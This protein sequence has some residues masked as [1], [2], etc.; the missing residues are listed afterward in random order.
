MPIAE[1]KAETWVVRS[2][3]FNIRNPQWKT[4]QA[5]GHNIRHAGK[6]QNATF[7]TKQGSTKR[8]T[9]VGA[10]SKPL[11]DLRSLPFFRIEDILMAPKLFFFESFTSTDGIEA[12]ASPAHSPKTRRRPPGWSG[13]ARVS[14]SGCRPCPVQRLRLQLLQLPRKLL[15]GPSRSCWGVRQALLPSFHGA[16]QV[17]PRNSEKVF[18]CSAISTLPTVFCLPQLLMLI[19]VL[20]ELC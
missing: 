8:R 20:G 10:V 3:N 16:L 11:F 17:V 7:G 14:A 9:C 1:S 5:S 2:P 13:R 15:L 19:M 6:K 12:S 18:I 4:V